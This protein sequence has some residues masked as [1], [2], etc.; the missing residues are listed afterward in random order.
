MPSSGIYYKNGVPANLP[1]YVLL[2]I[3]TI[4]KTFDCK[5]T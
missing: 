5:N 2:I 1:M 4:I 3:V